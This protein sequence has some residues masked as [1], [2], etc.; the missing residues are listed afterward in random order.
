MATYKVSIQTNTDGI[1]CGK[2]TNKAKAI[3][4]A[5]YMRGGGLVWRN[6]FRV[7]ENPYVEV[8]NQKTEDIVY[9]KPMF[10]NCLKK[11]T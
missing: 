6:E 2:F 1:D 5:S 3:K 11:T 4:H 10:K 9:S 7:T 8:Y